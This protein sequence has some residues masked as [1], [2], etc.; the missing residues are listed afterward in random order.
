MAASA[1]VRAGTT[2]L[3]I[4][5]FGVFALARLAALTSPL[6]FVD[7]ATYMRPELGG[8]RLPMVPAFYWLAGSD[9]VRVLA[10]TL[11]AIGCWSAAAW[12]VGRRSLIAGGLVLLLGLTPA[13][14]MWDSMILSESLSLSLLAAGVALWLN[15][16]DR[17][18]LLPYAVAVTCGWV[19]CRQVNLLGGLVVLAV[20]MWRRERTAVLVLGVAVL[21]NLGGWVTF[22]ERVD[23]E[24][25]QHRADLAE[26]VGLEDPDGY[27]RYVIT[28][29]GEWVKA[30][31]AVPGDAS[32]IDAAYHHVPRLVPGWLVTVLWSSPL[33]LL[34]GVG[35]VLVRRDPAALTALGVMWATGAAAWLLAATEHPR[36]LTPSGVG[37]RVVVLVVLGDALQREPRQVLA[38]GDVERPAGLL[39]RGERHVVPLR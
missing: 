7:S 38:V 27:E 6:R 28:H 30:V 18:E 11:V 36:L 1:D 32:E 8:F 23:A 19:M 34:A 9:E 15:V 26:R 16:K 31:A 35:F 2:R 37:L 25:S 17:P 20:M 4:A 14:T 33:V 10:Q 3:A 13:V 22:G 5:A 21:V 12:L 29:P 24:G 39:E